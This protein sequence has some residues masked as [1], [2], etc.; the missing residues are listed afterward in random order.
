M[1]FADR[2]R[3]GELSQF[4]WVNTSLPFLPRESSSLL[5][6]YGG[7]ISRPGIAPN[8]IPS[9]FVAN[10]VHSV[11]N[12][13]TNQIKSSINKPNQFPINFIN[14]SN[15]YTN[16]STVH[17]PQKSVEEEEYRIKKKKGANHLLTFSNKEDNNFYISSNISRSLQPFIFNSII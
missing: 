8:G 7:A 1:Y 6:N 16:N 3:Y 15:N 2:I 4:T 13:S 14:V 12:N 5:Y 11:G 10:Q 17:L 9:R